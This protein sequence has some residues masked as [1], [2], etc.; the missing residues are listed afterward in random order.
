MTVSS[1]G[2]NP[3]IIADVVPSDATVWK[4]VAWLYVGGAGNL[5]LR[6]ANDVTVTIAAGAGTWWPFRE[7][8]VM[9]ATTAT[10]IVAFG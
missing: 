10:G 2:E 3:P 7:G 9:A 8:K 6:G 5:M 1:R 4:H